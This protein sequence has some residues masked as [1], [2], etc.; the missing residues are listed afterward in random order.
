MPCGVSDV[1]D[2]AAIGVWTP[3]IS[4]SAG[5]SETKPT[6]VPTRR[7]PSPSAGHYCYQPV[8][9]WDGRVRARAATH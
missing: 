7:R 8:R 5:G 6:F 3:S 4:V 1:V 2:G 9:L